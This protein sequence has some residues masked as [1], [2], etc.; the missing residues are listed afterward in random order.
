M[1]A[2][3]PRQHISKS[4]SR[5]VNNKWLQSEL[6]RFCESYRHQRS[7]SWLDWVAEQG[8]GEQGRQRIMQL[9]R[10]IQSAQSATTLPERRDDDSDTDQVEAKRIAYLLT[11]TRKH[12][13]R[14]KKQGR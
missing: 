12:R 3:T 7:Q 4:A 11:K 5:L 6:D 14:K 13:P 2:Q 8:Q 1:T 9:L 10:Q